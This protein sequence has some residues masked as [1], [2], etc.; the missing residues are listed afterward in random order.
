MFLALPLL[1]LPFTSQTYSLELKP[2]GEVISYGS[3]LPIFVTPKPQPDYDTDILFPLHE[4]QAKKAAEE[5]R[6]A[7]LE[8]AEA[9]RK[10]VAAQTAAR[11]AQPTP[12]PI[13]VPVAVSGGC[14]DWIA[15]AGVTDVPS[16]LH[17]IN[18]ESGCNPYAKNKGSGACGIGQSLPCSKMGAV[19]ADG[20]SAL[21]PV[22]Q[23]QWMQT[24]VVN[25]YGSWAA[26][27]AFW[28]RTDPRPYPGHWY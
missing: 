5:A 17:L 20:T 4:A 1:T 11:V 15:A 24:Y 25:R 8:A 23:I 14:A 28:Q 21:S 22:A 9:Q 13:I 2:S 19:N 10:V 27:W 18:G 16:A 3:I 12:V 6:I 7:A 26:A